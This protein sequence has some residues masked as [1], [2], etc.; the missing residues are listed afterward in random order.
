MPVLYRLV[1]LISVLLG[2][3]LCGT[4]IGHLHNEASTARAEARTAQEALKRT[5]ATLAHRERLRAATAREA[6]SA[7]ASLAATAASNPTWANTPVPQ[8]VQDALCA[9]LD[10]RAAPGGL[11]DSDPKH[12]P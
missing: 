1:A 6:A 12:G 11:R 2:L 3:V 7:R 4:Y 9:H 8:E 10:C 5:Q